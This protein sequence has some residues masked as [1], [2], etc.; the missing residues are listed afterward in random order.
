MK[1]EK[2]ET[3][4]IIFY[5][6]IISIVIIFIAADFIFKFLIPKYIFIVLTVS[7]LSVFLFYKFSFITKKGDLKFFLILTVICWMTLPFFF[8]L[9]HEL[10]HVITAL[11][12][13]FE[14][15]SIEIYWPY[16]GRTHLSPN[17]W[18]VLKSEA[19]GY[20]WISLSGSVIS[21]LGISIL[22][23]GIYHIKK[24]RFSVFFPI[25]LITSWWI[26]FEIFYWLD[27]VTSYINGTYNLNDAYTFLYLY[28]QFN[29][30]IISIDPII[31]RYIL[32]GVLV[33]LLIWFPINLLKRIR[34]WSA[35]LTDNPL[36]GKENLTFEN[37]E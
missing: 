23:R 15:L 28:L 17:S 35:I 21:V 3:V 33:V 36:N 29:N 16:G 10:S 18:V 11:I 32:V 5:L 25:F 13:G 22:N 2:K 14:V 34:I 31:L 37:Y 27:G 8:T 4:L 12:N 30:P 24:I 20:C 26:L 19:V 1:L 7:F 6:L 9:I